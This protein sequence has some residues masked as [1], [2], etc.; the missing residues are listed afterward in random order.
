[1]I[2]KLLLIFTL[3][4]FIVTANSQN[5]PKELKSSFNKAIGDTVLK[6]YTAPMN[7]AEVIKEG[8]DDDAHTTEFVTFKS[9][10][11]SVYSI[12]DGTV[13]AV[14]RIENFKIVI[15]N[16]GNLFYTY[17]NLGSTTLKRGDL[18]KKD[19]LIGYAGYNLDGN[20]PV[21]DFYVSDSAKNLSLTK[22]NFITRKDKKLTDHSFDPLNEPR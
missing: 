3:V 7:D 15:I 19:Q 20:G 17:S 4:A 10:D 18:V 9:K 6:K 16:N 5:N 22:G 14:A 11:S 12:L 21:L 2:K 1:M 13:T 8:G